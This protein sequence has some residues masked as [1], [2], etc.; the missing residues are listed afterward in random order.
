MLMMLALSRPTEALAKPAD[1]LAKPT[2]PLA[3]LM[4][5]CF[6]KLVFMGA[7]NYPRRYMTM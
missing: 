7:A 6:A 5:L 4:A 3:R 2:L 1:C